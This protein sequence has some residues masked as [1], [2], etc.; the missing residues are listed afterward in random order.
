MRALRVLILYNKPVLSANHPNAESEHEVLSTVDAV[1]AN[2]VQA[3]FT[4]SCLGADHHPGA[5]LAGLRAE[6]EYALQEGSRQE[7]SWCVGII[8]SMLG[9]RQKCPTG[10]GS[11]D[12]IT[13]SAGAFRGHRRAQSE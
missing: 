13:A 12:A 1:S 11:P 2:L 10:A 5:L 3:G 8:Y 4:V 9:T 7:Y 6:R